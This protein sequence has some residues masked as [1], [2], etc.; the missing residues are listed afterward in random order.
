MQAIDICTYVPHCDREAAIE[1]FCTGGC[2]RVAV[3]EK[4]ALAALVRGEGDKQELFT[5]NIGL[6][7]LLAFCLM[8]QVKGSSDNVRDGLKRAEE[9]IV[10]QVTLVKLQVGGGKHHH[11]KEEE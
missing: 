2:V 8:V 10:E 6:A 3:C 5:V 4:E 11:Q 9:S 7:L 1:I